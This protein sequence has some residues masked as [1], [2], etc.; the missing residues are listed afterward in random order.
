MKENF[1]DIGIIGNGKI[2]AVVRLNRSATN[3]T[4]KVVEPTKVV[5]HTETKKGVIASWGTN[6]KHPQELLESIRKN[7]ATTSGL[8]A[9]SHN[10]YGGGFLLFEETFV[11]DGNGST[12]R[13]LIQ[14]S[15]RQYPAID[16]FFK[17]SNMKRFHKETVVDL[18]YF[19]IGFPE[20][21]LSNDYNLISKVKRQKTAHCRFEVMDEKGL[22]KN[23]WISTKWHK[24]VDLDS[25]YANDVRFIS[26]DWS[27]DEVKEYCKKNKIQN[28]I[29][30]IFYAM[31]DESY[32]P[33]AT[34]HSAYY[35]K[36]IDVANSIPE[37]K[38]ALFENQMNIKF[39]IEIDEEYFQNKYK[40]TWDD[41]SDDEKEKKRQLFVLFIDDNL[42]G[43]ANAATSIWSMIYKDDEGKPISG[44]KITAIDDKLKDG[45]FLPDGKVA[46]EQIFLA[47]GIDATVLSAG[48]PGMGAGSGSDKRVAWNILSARSKPKR[49]T[50]LEVFEFIQQY[51]NWPPEL[52]GA[53]E[54]TQLQTLDINPTGSKKAAN[55]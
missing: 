26:P 45:A 36:W 18:E 3:S 53:F 32:Y 39:H 50:T 17:L 1:G 52:L 35:S 51:N 28:F 47:I 22:I 30:P 41:F 7:A 16:A 34:W 29:R 15:I 40:E 13:Q 12:K 55:V 48:T 38:K 20:Y 5:V 14:K 2:K 19:A 8:S 27:P 24:S 9:V 4:S 23:V 10:H 43:N 6:N 54:D 44:L 25:V 11:D 31:L 21:V 33:I 37:F 42:R 49:E 46:D